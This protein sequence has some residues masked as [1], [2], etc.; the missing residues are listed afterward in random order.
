M[1]ILK[2]E[3]IETYNNEWDENLTYEEVEKELSDNLDFAIESLSEQLNDVRDRWFNRH[4]NGTEFLNVPNGIVEDH[5][6][7]EAVLDHVSV[8]TKWR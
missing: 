1:K 2:K 6:F 8:A 4:K 3:A 5:D 7:A